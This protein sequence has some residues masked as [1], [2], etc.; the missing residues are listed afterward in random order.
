M[1]KEAKQTA[2]RGGAQ[3]D[4]SS[5]NTTSM[6]LNTQPGVGGHKPLLSGGKS[7]PGG[8]KPEYVGDAN[9]PMPK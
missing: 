5:I 8:H 4:V 6:A 3:V 2:Y 9:I 7:D 1:A